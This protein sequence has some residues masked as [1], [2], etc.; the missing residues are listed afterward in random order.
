MG[1]LN[2]RNQ[3]VWLIL[4][5]DSEVFASF[6]DAKDLPID[7]ADLQ[8]YP[9]PDS[10]FAKKFEDAFADGLNCAFQP[11]FSDLIDEKLSQFQFSTEDDDYSNLDLMPPPVLS[12]AA[13]PARYKYPSVHPI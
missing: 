1:K 10:K 13:I 3:L 12:T 11:L 4:S 6:Y 9:L 5:C 8:Y 2:W 7:M